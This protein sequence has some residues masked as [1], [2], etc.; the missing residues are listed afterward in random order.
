[1]NTSTHK[2]RDAIAL[3]L[4]IG[5]GAS[6]N[7]AFAQDAAAGDAQEAKTLDRIEVTGSNIPRTDTETASPVQVITRQE[8]DRTGKATVAEYLQTLTADGAGSVPKSFGNGFAGGGAGISLRGLGAGSTLV[9]LNGRRLAPFGLADD[10][11]K[12]FTDLS[13]IPLEAV[14]RIDVLKDGASAVYGSDA[15]AGVVNIILRKNF[16]GTVI[17]GTYGVS[18]EGDGAMRKGSLTT[19]WGDLA[20]DGYN[21]F[22]SV[23]GSK[24][25]EIRVIDRRDRRWIGTGDFRRWGYPVLSRFLPGAIIGGG[26]ESRANPAGAL[27]NPNTPGADFA[28]LPGCSQLSNV[29]PQDPNGGCLWNAGQFRSLSPKEEYV[30]FF[31]RGTFAISDSAE[32]YSEF[33]YSKKKTEFRQ[34]PSGISNVA[35]WGYPGGPV[36]ATSGAGA[37]VLG[38]N[39]PDNP[40]GAPARLRY[41]A[42][43]VGPI[44]TNNDIESMRFLVGTKG[45]KGAWD[46]DF[47]YLHSQTDL[48]STRHG[49]LRYSHVRT[50]LSD[51]NSPVGYWRIGIHSDLN[52]QALYDYIS[53]TIHADGTTRLDIVDA[54]ASR[55]LADLRGGALGL[56]FGAEYRRQ[57]VE[58]TPQTYTDIGDIVGLG[59][60]AYGGK[61]E[62]GSAYAE[63]QAPVLESLELNGAVRVDKYKDGETATTPKFGI[64]WKPAEWL[65]LRATYAEGFRAPNPAESGNGGLAAFGN[66]NDPVRCAAPGH[67]PDDCNPQAIALITSPN[68]NLKPE[69]SKSYTAGI[70]LDPTPNTSL[71]FDAFRIKRTD[72]IFAGDTDAAIA[73]GGPNVLRGINNIPGTPNSGSILAVL[74]AYE[75]ASSTTVQGFDV[76]A[77]QRFDLGGAGELKLDLQWTRI[78]K[79]ER[80]NADGSKSEFAGTHGDCNVTN[81][82]GTP[83]NRANFGAT[84]EIGNVSLS[85]VANWRDSI[86]NIPEVGAP[87]NN[88]FANGTPAPNGCVLKAFYTIDLSGSWRPT[89]A[90][91][92]FGSVSNVTDRIA[93]LDPVTYGA[94]GYD[95][96]DFSGA[97]GRYYTVGIKYTF[98]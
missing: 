36:D 63:L 84:W 68:P 73:A 51:P 28:S 82:I 90:F 75:N 80:V 37:I 35:S 93:P 83:K 70:V 88:A 58:L 49:Q 27:D 54:K 45:S 57:T 59:F 30:N 14:E 56:A 2:L 34:P 91:E 19:G 6:A 53:P 96:L 79:L 39:H 66:A 92:V 86:K 42:F 52:S 22:F 4:A 77:R 72:E 97:I 18:G 95:P 9:L 20:Q 21:F 17:K 33:S 46:Y 76:D 29:T 85:A 71:T 13:T 89:E 32:L 94:V 47:S 44:V 11:Q 40:Y 98:K 81:C 74:V 62:V 64:K 65:A 60:S 16:E 31:A 55:S 24:T 23:E 69:K 87:C 43:D 15:I 25:D 61:E 7:A 26:T 48:T 41:A 50:A 3:A 12:V 5:A 38:A 78:N 8:I 10:G 67:T 1:M